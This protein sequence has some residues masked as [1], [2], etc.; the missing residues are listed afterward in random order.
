MSEMCAS[1]V[2]FSPKFFIAEK[3]EGHIVYKNSRFS[4]RWCLVLK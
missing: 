1:T 2:A 3:L 4:Q